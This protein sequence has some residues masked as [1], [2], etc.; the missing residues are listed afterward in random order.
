MTAERPGGGRFMVAG[1]D[2]GHAQTAVAT[3]W[4]DSGAAPRIAR[5]HNAEFSSQA[6]P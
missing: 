4:A 2:L 6:H 5:L 3:V 1:F